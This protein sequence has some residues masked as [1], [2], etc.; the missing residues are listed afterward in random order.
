L[1]G[2]DLVRRVLSLGGIA[3]SAGGF[4]AFG[5]EL[6]RLWYTARHEVTAER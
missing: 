6:I 1:S 2:I 4:M 3:I 5:G